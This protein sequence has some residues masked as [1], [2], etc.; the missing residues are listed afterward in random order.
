MVSIVCYVCHFLLLI[1]GNLLFVA[2]VSV[3]LLLWESQFSV[4][5]FQGLTHRCFQHCYISSSHVKDNTFSDELPKKKCRVRYENGPSKGKPNDHFMWSVPQLLN[6]YWMR[7]FVIST[8]IK[9][10]VCVSSQRRRLRAIT[11]TSPL[12][13]LDITKNRIQ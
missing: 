5:K 3:T 4:Q 6:N 8:I 13:I 1:F 9:S 11:L 7:F 12:I 2:N 10:E